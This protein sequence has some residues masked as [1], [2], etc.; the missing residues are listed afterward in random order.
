MQSHTRGK[1]R[2]RKQARRENG[3]GTRVRTRDLRFWSSLKCIDI[4]R[5]FCEKRI[6]KHPSEPNNGF[7]S[8]KNIEG[9]SSAKLVISVLAG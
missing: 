2:R 4:K 7:K 1:K 9:F 3:R 5:F 6:Q 8:V